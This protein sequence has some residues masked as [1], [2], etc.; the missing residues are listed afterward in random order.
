MQLSNQ[1]AAAL[2]LLPLTEPAPPRF[3]L[4]ILLSRTYNGCKGK[5]DIS[6][7]VA[8]VEGLAPPNGAQQ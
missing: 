5:F 8:Y 1:S 2:S 6:A 3:V 7:Y 4:F